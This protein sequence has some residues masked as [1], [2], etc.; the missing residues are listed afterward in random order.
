VWIQCLYCPLFPP[1]SLLAIK[2]VQKN[3]PKLQEMVEQLGKL[4]N[5]IHKSNTDQEIK[6][7]YEH[8]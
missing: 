1:P 8:I 4:L 2:E 5:N 3:I 6:E 7:A